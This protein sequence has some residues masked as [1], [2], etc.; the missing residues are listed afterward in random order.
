MKHLSVE[1]KTARRKLL[2]PLIFLVLST[3]GCTSVGRMVVAPTPTP[4]QLPIPTLLPTNTVTPTPTI[5]PSPTFTPAPTDT[6]SPTPLPVTPTPEVA[7]KAPQMTNPQARATRSDINARSGPGL[8]FGRVGALTEG[9]TYDIVGAN[10]EGTWWQLCCLD[11]GQQGWVR[12]DLIEIVGTLDNVTVHNIDTPV[13][14]PI[15]TDTPV[16]PTPTP[17]PL[18]YRG[19]GPIFMPTN[20]PWVTIWAKI[21]GGVGNGTPIPGWRIQVKKDGAVVATSDPSGQN[22]EYSA[23][24]GTEFGNRVTYNAKLEIQNPGIA[25]WEVYVIDAGGMVQSPVVGFTTN[26]A[27]PN[28]EIYVGFLAAQ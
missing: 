18:F 21:Y 13:P 4:T 22:F 27:N 25:D 7:L 11:D 20:N 3:L 5:T 6:P 9:R 19:I 15:P 23:P 1:A 26:P 2:V 14:T 16:P 8:T 17:A 10:D 12:A 24:A 28:R